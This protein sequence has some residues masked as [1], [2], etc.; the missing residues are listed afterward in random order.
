M[1]P[2][3]VPVIRQQH[4]T[5][6]QGLHKD[7]DGIIKYAYI[8]SRDD[9]PARCIIL[10]HE[11]TLFLPLVVFSNPSF[12]SSYRQILTKCIIPVSLRI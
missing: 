9:A 1:V 5:F 3:G 7:V 2:K 12:T 4:F 6:R 11:R 8:R 10:F